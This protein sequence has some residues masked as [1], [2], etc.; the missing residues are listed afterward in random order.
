MAILA[1]QFKPNGVVTTNAYRAYENGEIKVA[2][3]IFKKFV[4]YIIIP[5]I[6]TSKYL[7]SMHPIDADVESQERASYPLKVGEGGGGAKG[8]G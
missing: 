8:D 2:W 6:R 7:I 3:L 5:T 1:C 4:K